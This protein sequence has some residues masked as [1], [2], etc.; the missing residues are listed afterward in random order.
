MWQQL[1]KPARFA[2]ITATFHLKQALADL[3]NFYRFARES[4]D[5]S[6]S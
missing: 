1:T 2:G 3:S 4:Y 5:L 6:D